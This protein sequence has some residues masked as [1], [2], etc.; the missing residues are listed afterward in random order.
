MEHDSSPSCSAN[1]TRAGLPPDSDVKLTPRGRISGHPLRNNGYESVALARAY[2]KSAV[3]ACRMAGV[4]DPHGNS[5]A[6][7]ARRLCQH[8][9]IRERE[10]ELHRERVERELG[11]R[12]R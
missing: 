2:G 8:P 3:E 5:F 4:L 10:A 6:S 12:E 9:D 11:M 1:M 7:N